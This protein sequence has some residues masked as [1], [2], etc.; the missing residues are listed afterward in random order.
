ML[1]AG[2]G[3]NA[4]AGVSQLQLRGFIGL[5]RRSWRKEHGRAAEA[6]RSRGEKK[7]E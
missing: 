1:G 3:G 2:A 5:R 4:N 7:I 6:T